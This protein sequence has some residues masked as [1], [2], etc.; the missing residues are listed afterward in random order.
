M[1]LI[2]CTA[3]VLSILVDDMGIGT[4][5]IRPCGIVPRVEVHEVAVGDID[6]IPI[7]ETKYGQV[8]DLPE[9]EPETRYIVSTM[10]RLASDRNDLLSPGQLVL[11]ADGQPVGCKGLRK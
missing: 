10:V 8:T 6:G 1:K 2:N 5:N 9:P 11:G 3:H 4:R 7:F